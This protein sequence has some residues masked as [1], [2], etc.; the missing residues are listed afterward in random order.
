MIRIEPIPCRNTLVIIFKNPA[1]SFHIG[2][3]NPI[4]DVSRHVEQDG[5]LTYLSMN[6]LSDNF[7]PNFFS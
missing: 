1:E 2:F 4:G 5:T 7:T 3:G 6:S